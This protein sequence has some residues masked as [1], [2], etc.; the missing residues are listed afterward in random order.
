M[1][2]MF[3]DYLFGPTSY[4]DDNTRVPHKTRSSGGAV[5]AVKIFVQSDIAGSYLCKILLETPS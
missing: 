2:T 4:S 5:G 3:S 1:I